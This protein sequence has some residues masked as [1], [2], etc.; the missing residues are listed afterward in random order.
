MTLETLFCFKYLLS[1]ANLTRRPTVHFGAPL[2]GPF[3]EV[4]VQSQAIQV[5]T[6]HDQ[7]IQPPFGIV[8]NK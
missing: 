7:S 2:N 5:G 8:V 3:Q 6:N 1:V 4:P